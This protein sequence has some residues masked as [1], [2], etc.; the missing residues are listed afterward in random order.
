LESG[1]G[2]FIPIENQQIS[3]GFFQKLD[4]VIPDLACWLAFIFPHYD[5]PAPA[6]IKHHPRAKFGHNLPKPSNRLPAPVTP[7]SGKI[8]S[9]TENIQKWPETFGFFASWI[10]LIVFVF[11]EVQVRPVF[12]RFMP[13]QI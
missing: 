12:F 11:F 6:G 4:I 10:H 5:G 1:W 8:D 2:R 3:T 9:I 13:E 7:P